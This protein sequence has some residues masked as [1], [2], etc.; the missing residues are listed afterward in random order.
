MAIAQKFEIRCSNVR[1]KK[2]GGQVKCRRYLGTFDLY[3][4]HF[5]CPNCGQ[6][7]RVTA[8]SLGQIKVESIEQAQPLIQPKPAEAE[9]AA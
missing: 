5:I 9:A 6:H 4:I 7:Y 8:G 2:D 1:N 3:S